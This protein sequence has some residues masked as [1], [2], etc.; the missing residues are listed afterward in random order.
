M[1][2]D[3]LYRGA[4]WL[5]LRS[6]DDDSGTP[7]AGAAGEPATAGEAESSLASADPAGG[8]AAAASAEPATGQTAEPAAAEPP[9]AKMVPQDRLDRA[10]AEKWSERRARESAENALRLANET[11]ESMKR[12]PPAEPG[13]ETDINGE[14]VVRRA[15][16]AAPAV[17][18]AKLQ[19]MANEIAQNTA[20]NDKVVKSIEAGRAAYPDFDNVAA[21]LQTY[22]DL[23]RPFVQALLATGKS[24][25]V[26]YAIAND[27]AEADR[28]LSLRDPVELAFAVKTFADGVVGKAAPKLVSTAPKP[29]TPKVGGTA[30]PV[31]DLNSPDLSMKDWLAAREK[32]VAAN[33]ARRR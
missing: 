28:I 9:V 27:T 8:D 18:P 2:K 3:R 20:F 4:S 7:A 10:T 21:K 1:W 24:H 33:P 11:I 32:Q 31:L 26:L 17:T 25:D 13:S 29:I 19:E 16:P 15:A 6:P 22:G 14:P 30:N 5:T 23:P 12:A